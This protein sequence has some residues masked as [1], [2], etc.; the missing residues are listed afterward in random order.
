[1]SDIRI[2][3]LKKQKQLSSQKLSKKE[4]QRIVEFNASNLLGLKII[5]FDY[6]VE[7]GDND[8]IETLAID[9]TFTLTLI[10]YRNG[11]FGKLINKGLHHIDYIKENISEVKI[12][13]KDKLG[14]DLVNQ[15]NYN[16]RLII[17][18][19]DFNKYDEHAIKS[20]PLQVDLIKYQLFDNSYFV[21]E[22]NYVSK[23]VDHTNFTHKFSSKDELELYKEL[24]DFILSL[25]DEVIEF[26]LNQT[27]CY[28]KINY[29]AYITFGDSIIINLVINNKN[30]DITVKSSKDLDKAFRYLEEAYDKR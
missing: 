7:N 6:P 26:G 19:D 12:L 29:F 10:E 20:L 8:V 9:E 1:M 13:I 22:K 17:I 14:D 18:G 4:L 27:L 2:V 30:K 5:D 21:L 16:P 25:G 15:I 24:R 11:K 28:R 3:N 23:V